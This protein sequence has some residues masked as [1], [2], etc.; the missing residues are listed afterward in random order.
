MQHIN[1]NTHSVFY[2]TAFCQNGVL[3]AT[4]MGP[5]NNNLSYGVNMV[6]IS[7]YD[8]KVLMPIDASM[9]DSAVKAEG[10]HAT[11]QRYC[12]LRRDEIHPPLVPLERVI[13][14]TMAWSPMEMFKT[15]DAQK[16]RPVKVCLASTSERDPLK[17]ADLFK[18]AQQRA[19]E[20]NDNT[21]DKSIGHFR[22]V[23]AFDSVYKIVSFYTDDMTVLQNGISP[24]QRV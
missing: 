19:D 15:P 8:K 21:R 16:G 14:A 20:W 4:P 12:K 13:E 5:Q 17:R 10:A 22:V 6:D 24:P 3:L 11:L 1:L 9:L 2:K 7:N 23:M 18:L